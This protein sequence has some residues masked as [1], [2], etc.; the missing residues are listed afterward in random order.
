MFKDKT[1]YAFHVL[2]TESDV[3]WSGLELLM[4]SELEIHWK[5]IYGF[6]GAV[7]E[8]LRYPGGYLDSKH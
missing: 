6:T 3:G 2:S 7:L 4:H 5:W 8:E 1:A